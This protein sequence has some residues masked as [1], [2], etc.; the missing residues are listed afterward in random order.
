MAAISVKRSILLKTTSHDCRQRLLHPAH[1]NP[2]YWEPSSFAFRK[3]GLRS[4][5]QV[6]VSLWHTVEPPVSD[7]PKCKDLVATYWRW[8]LTR[9][10]PRG[11]LTW[12]GPGTSTLWK[13]IYC[14]QFLSYPMC[15]SMLSLKFSIYSKYHSAHSIHRDQRM[16]QVVTYR[17]LKAMENHYTFRPKKWSQSLTGGF[18]LLEAPAVRLCLGKF[19]CFG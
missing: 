10:E 1:K 11:P 8:S 4:E 2:Y 18:L 19:W 15:S 6:A 7:H 5:K 13:I 12:R 3:D 9:I 14:M 17:R 16:C